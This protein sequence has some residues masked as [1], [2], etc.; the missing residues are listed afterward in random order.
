MQCAVSAAPSSRTASEQAHSERGLPPQLRT[1]ETY[2]LLMEWEDRHWLKDKQAVSAGLWKSLLYCSI[3]CSHKELNKAN[4]VHQWSQ[5]HTSIHK[6]T[7]RYPGTHT[8]TRTYMHMH[9][10]MHTH[11]WGTAHVTYVHTQTYMYNGCSNFCETN[12]WW[13]AIWKGNSCIYFANG[14]CQQYPLLNLHTCSRFHFRKCEISRKL[15][16]AKYVHI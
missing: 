10:W 6:F 5:M 11:K 12:I 2:Q 3:C 15:E 1:Q 14:S 8:R 7:H 4:H 13:T 9:A 16:H